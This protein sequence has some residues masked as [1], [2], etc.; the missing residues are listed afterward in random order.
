MKKFLILVFVLVVTL[1]FALT[2][3]TA[4]QKFPLT[5]IAKFWSYITKRNSYLGWGYWPGYYGIYPGKSPH[6]KYLKIYANSVALQAA[7]EGRRM[8]TGAIIIKENYGADQKTLMAVT[9]MYKIKGYNPEGGDWFWAKLK[10]NGEPFLGPDGKTPLVGKVKGCI[11]CHSVQKN[12][13][14]LFTAPKN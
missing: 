3:S 2:F 1:T 5:D 12:K 13:G 10:P 14:W 11:N 8:T 7:R 6:G 9:P 4:A